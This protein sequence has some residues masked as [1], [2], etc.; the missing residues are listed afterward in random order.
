[1]GA[2]V[3]PAPTPDEA[4]A[5]VRDMTYGMTRQDHERLAETFENLG[6]AVRA[7]L[8][9]WCDDDDEAVAIQHDMEAG[10]P[11]FTRVQ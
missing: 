2:P 4:E 1:M 3:G 6:A 10:L 11:G 7:K 9:G 5:K 8:A